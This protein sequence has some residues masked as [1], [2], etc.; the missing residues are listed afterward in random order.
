MLL[1]FV[2]YN[3][4]AHIVAYKL[5]FM[6]FGDFDLAGLYLLIDKLLNISAM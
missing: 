5:G 6:S 3:K 4:Q 1:A 2:A